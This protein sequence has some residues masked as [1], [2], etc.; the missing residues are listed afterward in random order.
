MHCGFQ[1][2]FVH[3]RPKSCDQMLWCKICRSIHP[4]LYTKY[5]VQ[6]HTH[7]T[8]YN[9]QYTCMLVARPW[10]AHKPLYAKHCCLLTTA[11]CANKVF[12]QIYTGIHKGPLHWHDVPPVSSFMSEYLASAAPVGLMWSTHTRKRNSTGT[13]TLLTRRALSIAVGRSL[14]KNILHIVYASFWGSSSFVES[15]YAKL[16]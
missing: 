5:R 2:S 7:S 9:A 4:V 16:H 15:G 12:G 8:S 3:L 6:E 14:T 1:S 11:A 13:N 10:Y